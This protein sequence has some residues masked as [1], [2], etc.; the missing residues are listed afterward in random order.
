MFN[1]RG[2]VG[3]T[4]LAVNLAG[5][6]QALGQHVAVIDL[7]LQLGSVSSMLE[8]KALERSLAELVMEAAESPTGQI[9][10]AIDERNGISVIAQ[11]GRIGE[12]GM[13]TPDRLPRFFLMFKAQ[14]GLVIIDG[15]RSFSDHAV[16]AMDGRRNIISYFS[17]YPSTTFGSTSAISL[18]AFRL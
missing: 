5:S 13:V 1:T 4:T 6:A 18:Q 10:S 8:G 12:I 2:G 9:K 15:V 11:E 7:D 16:T 17:R 3:A 14:H